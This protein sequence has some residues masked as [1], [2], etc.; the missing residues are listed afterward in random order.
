M[1]LQPFVENAIWHG[2]M[3]L[4]TER[5]LSIFFDLETDD[6]LLATLRDNGI[7]RYASA[8]LKEISGE[9]KTSHQSKGMSMVQ[10][11]LQLLQQQYDNPFEVTISDINGIN[12][13]V[14][15]TEVILKI[16]IGD[17]KFNRYE[18]INYR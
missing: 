10:Q 3:P 12:G 16:F 11:R 15:G 1:I 9:H 5:K 13:E 17:K 7:G 8:K 4:Q 6:I 14:H 18:S 2:L